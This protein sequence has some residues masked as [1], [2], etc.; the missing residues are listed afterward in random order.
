[1]QAQVTDDFVLVIRCDASRQVSHIVPALKPSLAM[2][3]KLS[4]SQLNAYREAFSLFDKDRDGKITSRELG[5]VMRSLGQ[6]PTEA[7]ISDMINE[8][9]IDNDGTVDFSEFITM[10][11]RRMKTADDQ[12]VIKEAFRVFD[13]NGN[14]FISAAE[15]RHVL[16]SI[17]DKLTEE[18]A[19]E[20]IRA[21]DVD[22][23]GQINY[24]EFSR[25]LSE[26]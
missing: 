14:G 26:M 5:T 9:D 20:M 22:G 11:A 21:A 4:E 17:G 13:R 16:T 18:E 8:I 23:D 10:M 7:E 6:T 19:D 2:A 24:E 1:M 15:L 25:V 12:E 3:E